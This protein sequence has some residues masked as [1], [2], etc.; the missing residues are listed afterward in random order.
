VAGIAPAKHEAL[1]QFKLQYVNPPP[2][3]ERKKKK[4]QISRHI[5]YLDKTMFIEMRE[6]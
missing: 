5:S 3:K 4:N 6:N 2:A 1:R